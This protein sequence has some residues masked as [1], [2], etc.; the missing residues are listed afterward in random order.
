MVRS[1]NSSPPLLQDP[2]EKER[3]LLSKSGDIK[4]VGEAKIKKLK[5]YFA[6]SSEMFPRLAFRVQKTMGRVFY[7]SFWI[8]RLQSV[9]TKF[10]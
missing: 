3:P 4:N 7:F 5:T 6:K 2:P 9:D 10:L 8:C 1:Q